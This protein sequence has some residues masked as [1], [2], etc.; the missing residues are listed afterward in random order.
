M[1]QDGSDTIPSHAPVQ[2]L[3]AVETLERSLSIIAPTSRRLIVVVQSPL[4]YQVVGRNGEANCPRAPT[5]F[6]VAP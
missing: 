1:T 4:L 6:P 3:E 5:V 2:G